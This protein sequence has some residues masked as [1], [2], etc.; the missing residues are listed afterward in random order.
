MDEITYIWGG[1]VVYC[2]CIVVVYY[3]NVMSNK[4]KEKFAKSALALR[5]KTAF[6]EGCSL[7]Q[8]R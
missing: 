6:T 7:M 2:Y 5:I 1:E 4:T 3:E 8:I